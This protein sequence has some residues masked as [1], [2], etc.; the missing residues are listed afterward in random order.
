MSPLLAELP[1]PAEA[2]IPII[3]VLAQLISFWKNKNKPAEE[4]SIFTPTQEEREIILQRQQ[5]G[6]Y[7]DEADDYVVFEEEDDE[8]LVYETQEPP[9]IPMWEP[10][11]I[12]VPE[13]PLPEIPADSPIMATEVAT[14]SI[15]NSVKSSSRSRR[16]RINRL[17]ATRNAKQDAILLTE[18]LG[19]PL[20]LRS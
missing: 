7:Y 8:V 1:F 2:I 18:I 4:E 20:S 11:S 9:P 3:I 14:S 16:N 12:R 6:D 15:R 10:P 19:K 13:E 5:E 17:L